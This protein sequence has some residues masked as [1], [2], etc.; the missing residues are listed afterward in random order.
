[1]QELHP[2]AEH[3]NLRLMA[4]LAHPDDESLGNGGTLARYAAEGI[5]ITLVTATRGQRGWFGDPAAYPG[6]EGLGRLREAELHAAAAALGIRDLVVLDYVDGE[7]SRADPEAVTCELVAHIRRVQPQ[8]V[9]TFGL[10]GGYGHPDHMAISQFTTAA[11]VRA[12]DPRVG[13]RCTSRGPHSVSK[14][15]HMAISQRHG[16]AYREAFG[17]VTMLVDGVERLPVISPEWL[18]GAR[19]DATEH[20]RAAW[21]AVQCHRSQLPNFDTLAS[22]SEPLK[23]RLWGSN[24]Y[25]RVFSTVNGGF[26]LEDDL[27]AGLRPRVAT[28]AT[29]A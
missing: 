8:V 13:H 7:L 3:S 1:M 9:L 14:L 15:Y 23:R 2:M 11:I 19:I 10:D 24:E 12:A 22:M 21:R 27:F 16:D 20:W 18:I 4:I 26:A 17:D 6:I 29:A 25:Q 28:L 5:E